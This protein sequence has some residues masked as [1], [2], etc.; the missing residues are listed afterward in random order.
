M[1][2]NRPRLI[3]AL[4]SLVVI[5]MV[6]W[7][8]SVPHA[9]PLL[10]SVGSS[11]TPSANAQNP[12]LE[13]VSAKSSSDVKSPAAPVTT[14]EGLLYTVPAAQPLAV[15]VRKFWPQT[16]F[17]T[18]SDLETA[19]RESNTLGKSGYLKAGQQVL[20]PG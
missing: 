9:R 6:A 10:A 14:P 18:K 7:I 11:F 19:M 15:V 3:V 13:L 1:R 5:V 4:V 16:R 20:I 17:M 2:G 12:H 8:G